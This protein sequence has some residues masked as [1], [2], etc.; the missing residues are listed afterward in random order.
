MNYNNLI[1]S[2][3][4]TNSVI[5]ETMN[6]T[7]INDRKE[8]NRIINGTKKIKKC[9][10]CFP[11]NKIKK[12]VI[13]MSICG[14]FVFHYDINNRPYIIVMPTEHINS[15]HSIDSIKLKKMFEAINIL[16]DF[17]HIFNYTLIYDNDT[18]SN[19]TKHMILKIKIE[20]KLYKKLIDE[21]FKRMHNIIE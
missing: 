4:A 13:G 3:L 12:H 17:L 5:N 16:C 14:N 9:Y 19:D 8:A 20:Q 2:E 18:N 7:P 1:A 11:K 10:R 6:E 21:H 15:I